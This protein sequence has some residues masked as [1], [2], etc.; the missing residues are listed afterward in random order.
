[1]STATSRSIPG[2]VDDLCAALRP[3]ARALVDGF[4]IPAS[5]LDVAMG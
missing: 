1:M 2:A 4:G 3:H 5:W